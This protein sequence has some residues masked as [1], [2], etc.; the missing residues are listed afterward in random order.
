MIKYYFI[1]FTTVSGYKN[2]ETTRSIIIDID[3]L[4]GEFN[5]QRVKNRVNEMIGSN[6][7][8][9]EIISMNLL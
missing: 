7:E 3:L 8:V 1:R 2:E 5:I 9:Y 6:L 4:K